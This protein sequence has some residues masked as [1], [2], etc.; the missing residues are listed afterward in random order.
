[1]NVIT[2]DAG[3]DILP[4]SGIPIIY[5][6]QPYGGMSPAQ[7]EGKS[8]A[9]IANLRLCRCFQNSNQPILTIPAAKQIA[10]SMGCKNEK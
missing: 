9:L 8:Y 10:R 1:M 7:M 3:R 5:V 2:N 4:S 6:A